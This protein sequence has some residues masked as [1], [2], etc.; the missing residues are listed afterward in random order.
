MADLPNGLPEWYVCAN[1]GERCGVQGHFVTIS[2]DSGE[3]MQFL[4]KENDLT[5][6]FEGFYCKKKDAADAPSP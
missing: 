5:V 3:F 2:E 1:C 6:P 4:A